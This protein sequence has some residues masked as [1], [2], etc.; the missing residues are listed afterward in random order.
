MLAYLCDSDLSRSRPGEPAEGFD[1]GPSHNAVVGKADV[2]LELP[3]RGLRP[4]S[5][6]PV[7]PMRV[8]TELAEAT[9]QL[10][11]I[12]AAHHGGPVIEQPVTEVVI[13]LHEGVPGLPTADSVDH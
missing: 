2:V 1:G 6:Y 11:H 3:N 9:L 8:E 5:Q 12:V 13:S 4:G 10:R 7:N